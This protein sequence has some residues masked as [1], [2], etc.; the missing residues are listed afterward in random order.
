MD[1]ISCDTKKTDRNLDKRYLLKPKRILNM[2]SCTM[3]RLRGKNPVHYKYVFDNDT[4]YL[5]HTLS[6]KIYTS[7]IRT[8]THIR[9]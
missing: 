8:F 2:L 3:K 9:H 4:R 6:I 5:L 7:N 1:R